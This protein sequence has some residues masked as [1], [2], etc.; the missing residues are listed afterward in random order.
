MYI[1]LKFLFKIQTR[2][3]AA[4]MNAVVFTN[5]RQTKIIV[6]IRKIIIITTL[7]GRFAEDSKVNGAGNVVIIIL[8]DFN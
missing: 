5:R 6:G 8:V 7:I 4:H 1:S 2:N 3:S